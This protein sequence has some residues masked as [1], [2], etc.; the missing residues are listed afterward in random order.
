MATALDL[1][2]LMTSCAVRLREHASCT[3]CDCGDVRAQVRAHECD[4]RADIVCASLRVLCA[5]ATI[6]LVAPLEVI[7]HTVDHSPEDPDRLFRPLLSCDALRLLC[8]AYRHE[9]LFFASLPVTI[10]ADHFA[11]ERNQCE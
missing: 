7:A 11:T 3:A 2:E 4:L 6:L 1:P 5:L 9:Y 8:L 10:R